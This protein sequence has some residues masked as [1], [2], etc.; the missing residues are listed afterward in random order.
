MMEIKN[1]LTLFPEGGDPIIGRSIEIAIDKGRSI[2]FGSTDYKAIHS[3]QKYF[4]A[5]ECRITNDRIEVMSI[6]NCLWP[7]I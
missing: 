3:Y 6:L 1:R 4:N 2:V 5:S 7:R